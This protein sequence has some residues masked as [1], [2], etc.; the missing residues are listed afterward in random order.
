MYWLGTMASTRVDNVLSKWYVYILVAWLISV[1]RWRPL[2]LPEFH[3]RLRLT[4]MAIRS[5]RLRLILPTLCYSFNSNNNCIIRHNT[6]N[7]RLLQRRQQHPVTMALEWWITITGRCRGPH[8]DGLL[9]LLQLHLGKMILT[10]PPLVLERETKYEPIFLF[11]AL[12][13]Q[14]PIKLCFCC[15]RSTGNMLTVFCFDC[16]SLWRGAWTLS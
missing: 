8:R 1:L 12:S 13:Y 14:S 11:K 5:T 9:S 15:A 6:I 3:C 7:T 4:T 10:T 2:D 16:W